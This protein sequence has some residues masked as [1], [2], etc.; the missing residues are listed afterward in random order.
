MTSNEICPECN[1]EFTFFDTCKPG[2]ETIDKFIQDAQLSANVQWK[3]IEWIPYN[4]F[5]DIK[6]IA[7]GGFG[8][9]YHAKWIRGQRTGRR[10]V[11]LKRFDG[12]GGIGDINENFLNEISTHSRTL[13]ANIDAAISIYG[14][15]KD[16]ETHK[17][18][19]V[20][21][22][23]N[24]RN[25][26]NFL[27]NNF[28][29]INWENKL[30]YL[31]ESYD[32]DEIHK[33]DIIHQDFHPGNI[34]SRNFS[35]NFSLHISD[36]GLTP[37]VLDGEESL[38]ICNGLPFHIP[39][40]ITQVIMRCWDARANIDLLLKNCKK[41]RTEE[42]SANQTTTTTAPFSYK[43]HPQAIY[44][45]RLLNFSNLPKPKNEPNFEKELEELTESFSHLVTND[46]IDE[47]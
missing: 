36:F 44:T 41:K 6:E 32:F 3:V 27:N 42:I 13:E 7:K 19:M 16:P 26:R 9:I 1:Q 40:L 37:E 33:L 17:Y 5:Q 21:E 29:N 14:I 20:L 12:I 45:S 30:S 35:E 39:K 28:N 18:M 4:K 47:F 43:T 2:N 22:Y 38:K 11:A 31:H 34:L 23:L 10:E 24:D 46:D 25:L 15:T 8:T